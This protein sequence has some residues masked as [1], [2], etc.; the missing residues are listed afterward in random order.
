M[1]AHYRDGRWVVL[2]VSNMNRLLQDLLAVH[3]EVG[4]C[5][6]GNLGWLIRA[7]GKLVAFDL[8][9]DRASR[10]RPSPVPTAD[11]AAV[12]DVVF[13]THEHGDHFGEATARILAE[14]SGCTFVVPANCV[15]RAA[16]VGIPESR[17]VI[18]RPGHAFE[19]DGIPVAPQ[20]ALHGHTEFAVYR[21][22]NLDDCGYVV[23]IG[24]HTFFQPGD[25]VL[26]Q[27]HLEDL[28]DVSV[29][30]VSPTLHNTHVAASRTLV[31]TIRPDFVFPQHFNTY[32][33]TDQ[34]S[35]WT[36]GYPDELCATLSAE[37]QRRFHKLDQGQIFR[38]P[39]PAISA[40]P[41]SPAP[42]APPAPPA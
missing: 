17:L 30:F 20:R 15:D 24:G 35:Y 12:L 36:V 14:R 26:L 6:L 41:E 40:T 32:R 39:P 5:W 3:N 33:V 8:D 23:T 27:Q 13:I 7:E 10:L 22:A 29:L 19:I 9:L 4:L 38:I 42:P 2:P 18:A 25:T 37:M 16:Q 21:R 28:A 11:L 1:V 34:N 31:E